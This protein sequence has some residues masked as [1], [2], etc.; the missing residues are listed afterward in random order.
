MD[1][2]DNDLIYLSALESVDQAN[3][4]HGNTSKSPAKQTNIHDFFATSCH[5]HEVDSEA[6]KTWIYPTNMAIREYQLNIVQASLF[7]NTLV[8]LPT[9]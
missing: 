1:D 5:V 3:T 8:A 7:K 9:G 6:Y 4:H 2:S